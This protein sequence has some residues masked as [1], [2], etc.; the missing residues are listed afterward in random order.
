LCCDE[1]ANSLITP[2]QELITLMSN[3]LRAII[4]YSLSETWCAFDY[5]ASVDYTSILSMVD[6]GEASTVYNLVNETNGKEDVIATITGTA[7]QTDS[8]PGT[9]SSGGSSVA[10]S[11]LYSITGLIT[12]LF[13]V[14]IATGAVRAHRYPERYGPRRGAGGQPRQS[15]AR[16]MARAML[17]TIPIVKFNNHAPAKPD[18]DLELEAATAGSPHLVGAREVGT[19]ID[20]PKPEMTAAVDA[21]SEQVQDEGSQSREPA[22]AEEAG[23]GNEEHLGCS[24]CTEDF[25]VGEDVRVLPCNHQFH[26]QCVDPWLVNISGTCPLW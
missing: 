21:T 2:T 8:N 5:P 18:P 25:K 3:H 22:G 17:D 9:N 20:E 14:I 1:N 26:P 13:V 15:R 6:P 11:V 4:L 10:M 19:P 16:G 24:I 12:L 23:E 7:N